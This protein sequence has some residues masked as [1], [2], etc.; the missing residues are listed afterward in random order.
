MEHGKV[1]SVEYEKGIV[2]CDVKPIR[3]RTSYETVP[4]L[5]SHSGIVEMPEQGDVVAIEQLS[6]GTQFV[7]DVISKVD[8][9]PDSMKGGELVIQL[10]K[11]TKLGFRKKSNGDFDINLS[12]SGDLTV[13]GK[14]VS[15]DGENVKIDGIDFDEHEHD[16]TWGDTAGSGTTG[17]PK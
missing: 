2:Y 9:P 17:G 11:N 16:Y 1:T 14:N 10:D 5:K 7:S 13:E 8:Q 6:D 3:T 4:V 12:S 15:V